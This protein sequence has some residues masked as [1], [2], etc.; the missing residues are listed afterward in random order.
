MAQRR[1]ELRA[2]EQA[3]IARLQKRKK[4]REEAFLEELQM[5]ERE[6]KRLRRLEKE[7]DDED[8]RGQESEEQDKVV[9]AQ[10]MAE[11]EEEVRRAGQS[12]TLAKLK[13]V[14]AID[15]HELTKMVDRVQSEPRSQLFDIDIDMGFIR[16]ERILER[17]LRPWLEKKVDLYM[18]G[19][20]SDMVEYILRRINASTP[21]GAL[22]SDL[23]RYLEEMADPLVERMWR[24]MVFELYRGG[25]V[26]AEKDETKNA[27]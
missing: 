8:I 6:E 23:S 21:P 19:S 17:K 1:Q 11:A 15:M 14:A 3:R 4:W 10:K 16:S 5:V 9:Q 12:Q 20:Q 24:M 27:K 2:L 7:K 13:G 18:G 22:I 25:L 26:F